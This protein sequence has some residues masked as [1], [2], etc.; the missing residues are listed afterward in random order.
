VRDGV[1]ED[2]RVWAAT[3]DRQWGRGVV[4]VVRRPQALPQPRMDHRRRAGLVQ[5]QKARGEDGGGRAPLA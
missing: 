5:E 2:R 3:V 4:R 1:D